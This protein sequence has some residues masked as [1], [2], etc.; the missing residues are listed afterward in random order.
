MLEREADE[1]KVYMDILNFTHSDY[2][3][4]LDMWCACLFYLEMKPSHC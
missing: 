2:D 4:V 3:F 1:L